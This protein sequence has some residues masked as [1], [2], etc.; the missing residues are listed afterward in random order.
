MRVTQLFWPKD[1][2]NNF[3]SQMLG[4][5]WTLKKLTTSLKNY[6]YIYI[7]IYLL[8]TEVEQLF[9]G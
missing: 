9:W 4:D 1:G 5:Y 8:G 7:H 2:M 3:I 6:T